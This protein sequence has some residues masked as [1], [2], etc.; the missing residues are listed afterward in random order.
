MAAKLQVT[1]IL[2]D[3]GLDSINKI[4]HIGGRYINGQKWMIP[5]NQVI[6]R[7]EINIT[8]FYVKLDSIEV[9]IIVSKSSLG[10]KYIKTSRDDEFGNNLLN[11][12]NCF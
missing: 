12:P 11:L 7:I 8:S 1:C 5:V 10:V 3:D 2:K 4:S 6:D 9:D